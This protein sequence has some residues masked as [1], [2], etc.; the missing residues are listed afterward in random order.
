[1]VAG[2]ILAIINEKKCLEEQGTRDII[3][4]LNDVKKWLQNFEKFLKTET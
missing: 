2:N 3:T 4:K 1:M